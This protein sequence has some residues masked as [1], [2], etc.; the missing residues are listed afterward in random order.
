MTNMLTNALSLLPAQFQNKTNWT[1]YFTEIISPLDQMNQ[2]IA[3]NTIFDLSNSNNAQ[4][5]MCG[6]I[7]GLPRNSMTDSKYRSALQQQIIL[8]TTNG[9]A[10]DFITCI[11]ILLDPVQ[12]YYFN[13]YGNII[14]YVNLTSEIQTTIYDQI[15]NICPAGFGLCIYY[16]V[17]GYILIN[18]N[19]TQVL[20]LYGDSTKSLL[21]ENN[22]ELIMSISAKVNNIAN[23]NFTQPF[24]LV[25]GQIFQFSNGNYFLVSYFYSLSSN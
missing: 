7:I 14:C 1:N 6:N 20:M 21:L 4:L 22:N 12:F 24:G 16:T 13:N 3:D 25:N 23:A 17:N 2:S 19:L 9:T 8:N 15:L 11:K 18:N 10:E 5:D